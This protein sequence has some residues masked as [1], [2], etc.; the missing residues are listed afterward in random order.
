[1][2]HEREPETGYGSERQ[3][4]TFRGETPRAAKRGVD[5]V[6]CPALN[7]HDGDAVPTGAGDHG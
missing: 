3:V 2:R 1:V 4:S 7:D 5:N 6:F